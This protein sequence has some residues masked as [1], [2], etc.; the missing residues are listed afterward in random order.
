M[1]LDVEEELVLVSGVSGVILC[2]G[3]VAL[4]IGMGA[5]FSQFEWEHPAQISMS[6]GS[7]LFMIGSILLLSLNLLPLGLV[8]GMYYFLPE[9]RDREH[10]SI[11]LFGGTF[12]LLYILNRL[13]AWW[14]LSLGARALR[15]R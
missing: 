15:P 4:G 13:T 14:A 6:L 1:A 5:V 12:L 2:Y 9:L 11:F 8:L 10:F 7:F 3:L